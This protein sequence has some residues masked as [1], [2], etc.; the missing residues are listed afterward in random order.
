MKTQTFVTLAL[1][2][3][4]AAQSRPNLTAAIA[5]ENDTLSALAGT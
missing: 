5:S 4:A 2:G 3:L 1:S